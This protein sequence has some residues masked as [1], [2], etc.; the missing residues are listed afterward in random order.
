M[1]DKINNRSIAKQRLLRE[2]GLDRQENLHVYVVGDS[3]GSYSCVVDD[4]DCTKLY[5]TGAKDIESSYLEAMRLAIS[6]AV[7]CGCKSISIH[8]NNDK[9]RCF[10]EF[11]QESCYGMDYYAYLRNVKDFI[12]AVYYYDT[13]EC[14]AYS[15]GRSLIDLHN[16]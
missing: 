11:L 10:N 6:Y 1:I 5:G 16:S 14:D 8:Y 15:I 9:L 13:Q 7:R 12:T 3:S 4:S 2:S